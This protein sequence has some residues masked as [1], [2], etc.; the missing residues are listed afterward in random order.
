MVNTSELEIVEVDA[1]EW[2]R[3]AVEPVEPVEPVLCRCCGRR[4]TNSDREPIHTFPCITRH[5]R[6][7]RG[8]DA[9]RCHEY[10]GVG[11]G[12]GRG[13]K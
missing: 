1:A 9:R 6:H 10:R 4:V 2:A 11:R 12:T 8:K 7:Q 5:A 13:H 3:L